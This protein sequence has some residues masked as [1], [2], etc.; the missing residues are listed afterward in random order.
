[1]DR[2]ED[3]DEIMAG[4]LGIKMKTKR[5]PRFLS[6]LGSFF[7]G[8][9]GGIASV[10]GVFFDGSRQPDMS[11][12]EQQISALRNGQAEI[13]NRLNIQTTA[14]MADA[15]KKK[16]QIE[17]LEKTQSVIQD[18]LVSLQTDLTKESEEKTKQIN[19]LKSMLNETRT[20]LEQQHEIQKK[21]VKD[22]EVIEVKLVGINKTLEHLLNV[23][24]EQGKALNETNLK[25]ELNSL[26]IDFNIIFEQFEDEQKKLFEVIKK[27]K[28]GELDP[29]VLTPLNLIEMLQNI[30]PNMQENEKFPFYPSIENA[31]FLYNLIT[32][33]VYFHNFTLFFILK[34]PL[35][36]IKAFDIHK[37]TSLP[38][39]VAKNVFALVIPTEPFLLID[40]DHK[41]YSIMS[42]KEY[43]N[44]CKEVDKN[45]FLC[46][47][48]QP[49]RSVFSDSKCE[50][51]LYL[52]S[53]TI[54]DTCVKRIMVLT[55]VLFLQLMEEKSWIYVAPNLD[56]NLFIT[57]DSPM[58]TVSIEGTGFIS[59][60][61]NCKIRYKQFVIESL[62]EFTRPVVSNYT[63]K[64][65]LNDLITTSNV[66][67]VLPP[68]SSG[69]KFLILP[70]DL[71][72]LTEMSIAVENI[73]NSST[74]LY[75]LIIFIFVALFIGL[76]VFIYK[77][78]VD[79]KKLLTKW[80]K[81][82]DVTD[83]PHVQLNETSCNEKEEKVK[84]QLN[85]KNGTSNA[86]SFQGTPSKNYPDSEYLTVCLKVKK[87]D[88]NPNMSWKFN[89]L[90]TKKTFQVDD[91]RVPDTTTNVSPE[92]DIYGNSEVIV[93]EKVLKDLRKLKPK[94]NK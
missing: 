26:T 40:T 19:D 34:M 49:L 17:W 42:Y 78:N 80:C 5:L 79:I 38:T 55:D 41:D 20:K 53:R 56:T 86:I 25:V 30:I 35:V 70:F 83:N 67:S 45:V 12:Y 63:S 11:A 6:E 64:A 52:S 23:A 85:N 75:F 82:R 60:K 9:G 87:N 51:D 58:T 65:K 10:L 2:I 91:N 29:Y 14:F 74:Y 54:P 8:L 39:P 89:N 24:S 43:T 73:D 71:K 15:E 27:A 88:E 61:N 31:H 21:L 69:N 72:E 57:C 59:S 13:V 94:L 66:R 48:S 93:Q 7:S 62:K 44:F 22:V 76:Y 84:L 68:K 46:K 36:H 47:Q 1:M 4:F 81:T 37:I 3:R 92:D 28:R 77:K 90:K 18:N 16:V 50:I 32:P 33:E